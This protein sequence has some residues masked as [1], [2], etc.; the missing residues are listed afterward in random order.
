MM[1][2]TLSIQHAQLTWL[3]VNALALCYDCRVGRHNAYRTRTALNPPA[4][5]GGTD[6]FV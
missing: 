2:A 1:R 5:R 4:P 3:L 6:S